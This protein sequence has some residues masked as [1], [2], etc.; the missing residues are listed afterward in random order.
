M[1]D[2]IAL[3]LFAISGYFIFHAR[4][5]GPVQET[6]FELVPIPDSPAP[7]APAGSP[8]GAIDI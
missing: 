6:T 3:L 7:D 8:K 5:E 1:R 2:L 4:S